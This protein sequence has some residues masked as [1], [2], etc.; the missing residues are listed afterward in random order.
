MMHPTAHSPRGGDPAHRAPRLTRPFLTDALAR[1]C[2]GVLFTLLTMSLTNEFLRTGH[3]TGLLLVASEALVV[4]LTVLRRR[5]NLVDR[6]PIAATLTT[7]SVIGPPL[8][9]PAAVA[10]FA[11]DQACAV[12][13]A[14]GFLIILYGKLALGR[15]FGLIPAN[16]GVVTAGPYAFVRHPIYT[17]YLVTHVAFIAEYPTALNVALIV[18]ADA[19]LIWRA[20]REERVLA[21]DN[22]YRAYCS[23]VSWHL[24]PGLF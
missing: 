12:A 16:R 13:S 5:T 20:M 15:S 9:R 10:G 4:V 21:G 24:V 14:F 3:I 19:A 2:V 18:I 1:L 22:A 6:S 11:P 8:L 17:G 7:V 23:R